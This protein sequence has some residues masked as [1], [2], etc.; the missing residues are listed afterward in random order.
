MRACSAGSGMGC[1]ASEVSR[2]VRKNS[3]HAELLLQNGEGFVLRPRVSPH[4]PVS[5]V[6]VKVVV[7]LRA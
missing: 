6:T 4:K 7:C 2:S 3:S 5:T 1:D